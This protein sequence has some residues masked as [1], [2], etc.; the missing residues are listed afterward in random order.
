MRTW[1]PFEYKCRGW[2]TLHLPEHINNSISL[3]L[4]MRRWEIIFLKRRKKYEHIR[5]TKPERKLSENARERVQDPLPNPTNRKTLHCHTAVGIVSSDVPSDKPAC[6]SRDRHAENPRYS[7]VWR[8][9]SMHTA[10]PA[11]RNH[12]PLLTF[13]SSWP[14][15]TSTV[16]RH[17]SSRFYSSEHPWISVQ[18]SGPVAWLCSNSPAVLQRGSSQTNLLC[19]SLQPSTSA[20]RGISLKFLNFNPFTK[21]YSVTYSINRWIDR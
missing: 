6:A 16:S 20:S 1:L 2:K 4:L 11:D 21:S 14:I 15:C 3:V 12:H 10:G 17:P 13:H 5:K 8:L 9:S 19:E 18:S 7:W